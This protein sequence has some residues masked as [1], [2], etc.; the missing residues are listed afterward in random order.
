MVLSFLFMSLRF[1]LFEFISCFDIR[2][3]DFNAGSKRMKYSTTSNCHFS[4]HNSYFVFCMCVDGYC[5]EM[6]HHCI[7]TA[8]TQCLTGYVS[9]TAGSNKNNGI[10]N[11]FRSAEFPQRV[12]LF[13]SLLC[14]GCKYLR[15]LTSP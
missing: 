1:L 14:L 9:C 8:H 11:V 5:V 3:S 13:G 10:C 6:S 15:L 4:P 7:S 2:I 12:H